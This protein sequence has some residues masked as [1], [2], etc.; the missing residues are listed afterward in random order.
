MDSLLLGMIAGNGLYPSC[1]IQGARA[2]VPGIKIVVV[3]FE[4]E[5]EPNIEELADEVCWAKV[6]QF[7]K[8]L[9]FFKKHNVNRMVMV[10]QLAP[11]NLFN[12]RPDFRTLMMLA[13]LPRRNAETMFGAVADEAEKEGIHVLP[14]NIYMDDY[15]SK[16]GHIAGPQASA[17]Q[18]ED[19]M[20]GMGIAK[21]VSRLDIG[22]SVVVR[23]GTVLAVEGFEGTN[24]CIKRGGQLGRGKHV[25]LA[26]V[27]KANHDMRFDIP[28]I[29]MQTLEVCNDAGISQ[30]VLEAG[31]T[32]ILQLDEIR[33]FC[34]K[35]KITLHA[36]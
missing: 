14:S 34:R 17:R 25:T 22:Q 29:G 4:G 24:E 36:V 3:A 8:P 33:Q 6:G 19:A 1:L 12:L 35:H 13:K 28:V 18:M 9:K 20:Y 21:E 30:I 16:L 31:K 2:Q 11:K 10:G 15:M 27:A 32:V 5:T 23:H 7:T 26:K